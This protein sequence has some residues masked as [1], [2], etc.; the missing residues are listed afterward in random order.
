MPA[1]TDTLT[2]QFILACWFIFLVFWLITSFFAKKTVEGRSAMGNTILIRLVIVMVVIALLT[3]YIPFLSHPLWLYSPAAGVIADI[4]AGI[5]LILL[6]WSRVVLGR[7]WSAG[8]VLKEHHQLIQE[9]PYALIRH[10][11]YTGLLMLFLGEAVWYGSIAF[12]LLFVAV[13]FAFYLKAKTEEE[14]LA[15]HFP[16]E[17]PHYKARTKMLIPYVF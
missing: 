2:G 8:V 14:F 10:P 16:Q 12:F 5:G 11:I 4:I 7:N 15:K 13:S 6:L 9:G 3:H 1:I 17:Y